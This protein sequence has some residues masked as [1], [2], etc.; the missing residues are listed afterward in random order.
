MAE[1]FVEDVAFQWNLTPE[2]IAKRTDEVIER[3]RKVYDSVGALK[4]GEV[5]LESCLQ[6]LANNER[7]YSN[8]KAELEFLQHVSTDKEVRK[9][10]TEA[11]RKISE[12]DVEMSMRKDIFDN[13]V[14][15][16][17]KNQ[18]PMSSETKRLLERLIKLGKR[19]GLHLPSD[20]QDEIKAIKK[21]QSEIS[22]N[23]NSNLNE[24]NTKLSFGLEELTGLPEDFINSLEKDEQGKFI[25][26]LKYPHYIP[27]MRKA[28]NPETRR[29]MEYAFNRRCI[30]ENTKIL[31]ELVELRQKM[32]DLLGYPTH[33]SY[34]LE[35]RMAKTSKAVADF[36]SE[37]ATRLEPLA[38]DELK[39]LLK[40]KE[41]ECESLGYK[42]DG[43]INYWDM[44]YYMTLVEEKNYAVEHDKLKEYFP[45]DVVTKGLLDIYQDLLGLNFEEVEKPHVWHEDVQ[46]FSVKEKATSNIIG[47]FYLDLFPREGK[48]SHAA[49]FGLKPGCLRSDG[50]RQLSI[51]AMEANFT[52]P[53]EDKPSLLTH[54]EVETFFHEFGH[55]MHQICAKSEYALFSGTNV[56]RDFVEAPS[57]ML[58][59]WCWEPEPLRR[60]SAHYKDG[61]AIPDDMLAKLIASRNANAGLFNLRQI[62]LGTFDQTIHTSPKVNTA[63]VYAELSSKILHIAATPGTNMSASFGHLAGGY[64][65]QYY[66]Y[67]WS[68]VFCMD[69]FYSRFKKEGIMNPK[70]GVDYKTCILQPGGSI[71]A[72]DMLKNFLGRDPNQDA[73]LISKGLKV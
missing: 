7:E 11:D 39:A 24:E 47:Y 38:Q 3:S 49:C 67:L 42:F 53:T 22:I 1:Y 33:A 44:K 46:L 41:E 66:G 34:I 40:L 30:E 73:F 59:N 10:S 65:A 36:L 48:F 64:D 52:R 45:M 20:V 12:F 43:K 68:E 16:Q 6:A 27:C 18:A 8:S 21:K 28:S 19:N 37:L 35:M 63:D 31:E 2:D 9:A 15:L 62:L 14:A 29:K 17:E 58:E 23:F 32:A 51:A 13:L 61:S 72:S 4:P 26:T 71:D 69:M 70:V 5:T 25:L 54:N 56:E 55:V 50:K 60:M 57:Q